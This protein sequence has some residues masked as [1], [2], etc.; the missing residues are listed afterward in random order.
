MKKYFLVGKLIDS[1]F[2]FLLI[3]KH[4]LLPS[5][6]NTHNVSIWLFFSSGVQVKK[7]FKAVHKQYAATTPTEDEKHRKCW[8]F[9]NLS[10]IS[11]RFVWSLQNKKAILFPVIRFHLPLF[12]GSIAHMKFFSP[13]WIKRNVTP[14]KANWKTL[15]SQKLAIAVF[16]LQEELHFKFVFFNIKN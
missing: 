1:D 10:N 9:C 8:W 5:I 7:H 6:W 15:G 3:M 11:V 14:M 2:F 4:A 16:I 12:K 13:E